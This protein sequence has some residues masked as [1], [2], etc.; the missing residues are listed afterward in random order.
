M[1]VRKVNLLAIASI[2]WLIAGGNIL[3]I[4]GQLL[5]QYADLL[6]VGLAMAVFTLF[7]WRIFG[8]LVEK[9]TNRILS[10]PVERLAFWHFFDRRSFAIMALMMTMGISIRHFH[11]LPDRV[12]AFFYTGLGAALMLSGGRF[13]RRFLHYREKKAWSERLLQLAGM[14]FLLAMGAGVWYREFTK[15]M[16]FTG[17]TPLGLVHG[18]WLALG[19]GLCLLLFLFEDRFTLSRHRLFGWMMGI[20]QT[21]LLLMGSL[22]L[23][24]GSLI[25][26]A[27]P[28]SSSVD[29]T[30]AGLSGL[31]HLGLMIAGVMLFKVIKEQ[32]KA[33]LK[34]NVK[35]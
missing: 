21:S 19:T 4:G 13:G 5:A 24:R 9:Q 14:Y 10:Y 28:V 22:M 33:S 27:R 8:P 34:S 11:L 15:A 18:H 17:K 7:T 6:T 20:Y 1:T 25:V 26:L 3:W 16:H 32:W 2:V 31:T 23:G 29:G 30:I 12:I 35:I